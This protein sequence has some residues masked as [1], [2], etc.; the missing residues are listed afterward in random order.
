LEPD[1]AFFKTLTLRY[2]EVSKVR[3]GFAYSSCFSPELSTK[4]AP[5]VLD[6]GDTYL[7]A[8][9]RISE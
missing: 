7:L 8:T 9:M 4:P 3:A 5:T 6:F 1:R 2:V